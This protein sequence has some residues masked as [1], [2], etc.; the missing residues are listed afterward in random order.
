MQLKMY[1]CRICG[2]TFLGYEAP[3]N[4]PFCGAHIEFMRPTEEYPVDINAIQPTETERADLEASIEVE[5]SNARFYFGMA[6][7]KDNDLLR[8][9]YKRLAR[10]EAEH[11]GLFSKLADVPKPADLTT[12]GETTGAWLSDIDESLAREN[13]ASALYRT[14]AARATS[15]RLREVWDALSAVEADHI[16]LD[17]LAKQYA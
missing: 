17:Q 15:E 13:R 16:T 5:L 3:E 2:E 6:E 8:S 7:R 1:R 11:C 12:P 4:C 10:I 14:F 9:A